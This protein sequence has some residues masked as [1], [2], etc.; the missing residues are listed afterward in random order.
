VETKAAE[1]GFCPQVEP[2]LLEMARVYQWTAMYAPGHPFLRE[3]V[4]ALHSLLAAQLAQEPSGVLLIGIARDKILYRDRFIEARNPVSTAFAGELYRL[5]VATV[6]FDPEVTPEGLTSF[7]RCLRELQSGK[8]D[9]AP[10][11]YLK[12]QGIRGVYLSNVNYREV[13]SREILGGSAPV[14]NGKTGDEELWRMLLCGPEGGEAVEERIAEMLLSCP[15]AISSVIRKA[16][17][18]EGGPGPAVPAESSPAPGKNRSDCIPVELLLRI[19]RR[20][21]QKLKFLPEERQTRVLVSLGE[22]LGGGDGDG[23]GRGGEGSP[24]E[25]CVSV[26]GSLTEGY[27]NSELLELLAGLVT[28]ERKGG[29]RLLRAFQVIA[30]GRDAENSLVPLVETWAREGHRTRR[31]YAGKTWET[32]KRLLLDRTEDTYLGEE[33]NRFLE[34]LSGWRGRDGNA[35]AP[36]PEIEPFPGMLVD[37]KEVRRKAVVIL[38]DFLLQER[39]EAEFLDL[40]PAMVAEIPGLV[41]RKDFALLGR[42]LEAV[43]DLRDGD[44]QGRREGKSKALDAVPFRRIAEIALSDPEAVKDSGGATD[45]L[46]KYGA[47]SAAILLDRL[48]VEPDKGMRRVLL[49]LLVR[50]GEPAVPEIVARLRDFPWYFL[51]N[52]CFILGEIGASGTVPGLVRMLAHKEHRVRREAVQAL[53]KI[54]RVDP[55]AVSALGR[56]LLAETLFAAPKEEP[57]RIDAASALSRIGGAE[58]VSYLHRGK[59]SRR[60]AVREHCQALLRTMGGG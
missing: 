27:S 2:L 1:T 33:H 42:V 24:P 19:F 50:I 11:G 43:A 20:L 5:H 38:V 53:G 22:G 16:G 29:K 41:E 28:A 23:D 49:S 8:I 10:E 14:E 51:R 4:V 35:G 37:P 15:E 17:W 58:A 26:T 56:I 47:R 36:A 40:V 52:L 30:S 60:T 13:L 12:R 45:L 46:V 59:A 34:S 31:R 39:Q 48:L 18:S 57:V 3:R 32:V 9:D 21:G 6:G 44:S 55:D 7:F 54:R 25:F